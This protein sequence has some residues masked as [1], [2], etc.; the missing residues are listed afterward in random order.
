MTAFERLAGDP[1][2][3]LL[4][5]FHA[6]KH[7]SRFGAELLAVRAVSRARLVELAESLAPDVLS[8]IMPLT[9]EGRPADARA[10]RSHWTGVWA[11]ARKRVYQAAAVLESANP[12]PI[13]LLEQP[14]NLGNVG[15]CIRVAAGG[16]AAGVVIVGDVDPWAPM[17]VRGA[18]GLQYAVPTVAIP[19]LADTSRPI[20][21]LDPEG[22]ELRPGLIPTGA[23]LA[24]G[25]ER[26]G[27]S[28]A[29]R[30]RAMVRLRIPMQPGVS[31]LNLAVSLGI[32]LYAGR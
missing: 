9:T 23:I 20:V 16:G 10:E 30:S 7:A 2:L 6:V 26:D 24:F 28:A 29:L 3:V 1:S 15:A 25:T 19:A 22:E 17:V 13:V 12:A 32:A 5:G 11:V 8:H 27:L 18:A 14:R 4:T 31:S 21:A